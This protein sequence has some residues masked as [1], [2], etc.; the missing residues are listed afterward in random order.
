MH[1]NGSSMRH[2]QKRIWLLFLSLARS[3][4]SFFAVIVV[5]CLHTH[6]HPATRR[7]PILAY[8]MCFCYPR[9][10]QYAEKLHIWVVFEACIRLNNQKYHRKM[11]KSNITDTFSEATNGAWK[12]ANPSELLHA[13][14]IGHMNTSIHP[15]GLYHTT[16]DANNQW[17]ARDWDKWNQRTRRKNHN[18]APSGRVFFSPIMHKV[19]PVHANACESHP[20]GWLWVA[21]ALVNEFDVSRW[22]SRKSETEKKW[23]KSCIAWF[24]MT[25]VH[26]ILAFPVGVSVCNRISDNDFGPLIDQW[27]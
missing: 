23:K 7:F 17:I 15:P 8:W 20:V 5:V 2:K 24:C 19:V 26:R 4:R 21:L 10:W 27:K 16:V 6:A 25:L 9:H 14:Q 22:M 1:T 13:M 3:E 18:A 11:S 12:I